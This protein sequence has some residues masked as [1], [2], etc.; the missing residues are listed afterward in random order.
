AA[1]GVERQ[2]GQAARA[3]RDDAEARCRGA[4]RADDD[5]GGRPEFRDR[6]VQRRPRSEGAGSR[7]REGAQRRV[8]QGRRH[9][10]DQVGVP[11]A[12]RGR[13]LDHAGGLPRHDRERD[14]QA[15]S[16]G[17][18]LGRQS[19]LTMSIELPLPQH[20][21][22][23][24]VP[25]PERKDYSWPGGRRLAFTVTTN[26]E[27]F[28]F[29]AGLGHDPAKTGEPQ[30]H[31]NY[32]WRDYGNRVGIWRLFEL[33]DELKLPAGH[34]C[35]SLLYRYAPQIMDAIRKRGDEIVAHGR[36]NAENLKGLSQPDEE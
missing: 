13:H 25:L 15:S 2:G 21:R 30:P 22:Y 28:A 27:W 33:L 23:D 35:N 14:R 20:D 7:D 36:T 31:R 26:I 16:G 9:R 17:E 18:S 11:A 10:R 6:P 5:R 1:G 32:S 34:N 24:Y 4:R 12:R 3:R 8:R 19:R 29:G